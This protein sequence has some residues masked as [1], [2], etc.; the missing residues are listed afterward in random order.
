MVQPDAVAVVLAVTRLRLAEP[1][2]GHGAAEVPDRLAALALHLADPVPA[3]RAEQLAV[4]RQAA[5][6]GGDDEVD[7]MHSH[8]IQRGFDAPQS[9]PPYHLRGCTSSI[10]TWSRAA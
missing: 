9:S 8:P 6:D 3:E 5:L 7:V 4:E 10:T 1:D 2:L